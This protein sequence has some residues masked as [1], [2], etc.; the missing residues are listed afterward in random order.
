MEASS[1]ELRAIA[2]YHDAQMKKIT[3]DI[4]AIAGGGLTPAQQVAAESRAYTNLSELEGKLPQAEKAAQDAQALAA[5]PSMADNEQVQAAATQAQ[6]TVDSIQ[7]DVGSVRTMLG[8]LHSAAPQQPA[9]GGGPDISTFKAPPANGTKATYQGK[10]V[11]F[12]TASNSWA[13]G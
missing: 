10:P 13:P 9:A 8:Q 1:T 2:G 7:S 5:D 11:H 3:T 6:S 12:D 4:N